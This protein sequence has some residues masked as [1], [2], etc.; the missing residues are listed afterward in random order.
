M[1]HATCYPMIFQSFSV[2][3]CHFSCKERIL[4]EIF[5]I[6]SSQRIPVK[7]RRRRKNHIY[8]FFL[9]F[10]CN[11]SSGL[12]SQFFIKSCTYSHRTRETNV[13]LIQVYSVISICKYKFR[14]AVFLHN[15]NSSGFSLLIHSPAVFGTY[16]HARHVIGGKLANKGSK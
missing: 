11:C 14:C 9:R 13:F 7:I 1:F 15:E 10:I 3:S 4:T 6:S 5:R 8:F 16:C 2:I 12:I